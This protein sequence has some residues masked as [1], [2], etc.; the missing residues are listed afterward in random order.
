MNDSVKKFL[1][2]FF[3]CCVLL[4]IGDFFVPKEHAHF[5]WEEWPEFYGV[6]GFV[7]C[8]VLVMVAKHGL[9][10]LVMREE[11]YYDD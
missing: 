2:G 1:T 4:L 10:P 8:V 6:Y 7:S 9:R 3:V 11:D 5:A